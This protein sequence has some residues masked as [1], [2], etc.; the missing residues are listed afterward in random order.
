MPL[1]NNLYKNVV[2]YTSTELGGEFAGVLKLP[3]FWMPF[4]VH[5]QE[6]PPTLTERVAHVVGVL[7][8]DIHKRV[9]REK[10]GLFADQFREAI[11]EVARFTMWVD[12]S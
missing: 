10:R 12:E 5:R 11:K 1:E 2:Y 3:G 4:K 8:Q 7:L 9:P 6:L